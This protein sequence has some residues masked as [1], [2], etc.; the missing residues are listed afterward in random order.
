M[1]AAR[2]TAKGSGE[3]RSYILRCGSSFQNPSQELARCFTDKQV[4]LPIT[5]SLVVVRATKHRVRGLRAHPVARM[6][7]ED[8][9]RPKTCTA[10]DSASA[11]I[12]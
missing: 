2:R 8:I 6:I 9:P 4:H 10:G 5:A 11:L 12:S 1:T 7:A 3:A